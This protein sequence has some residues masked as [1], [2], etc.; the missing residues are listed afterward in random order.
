MVLRKYT[1]L[2]P[3]LVADPDHQQIGSNM[4]HTFAALVAASILVLTAPAQAATSSEAS[5]S[6]PLRALKSAL[7]NDLERALTA[8]STRDLATV[9]A[10]GF[11]LKGVRALAA[12]KASFAARA[13]RVTV[14][15]GSRTFGGRGKSDVRL[16]LTRPGKKMLGRASRITLTVKATFVARTGGRVSASSRMTLERKAVSPPP[17]PIPPIPPNAALL[18]S[19]TFDGRAPWSGLSTQCAHPVGWRS[20]NG[21][22]YAHFEVRPGEPTVAGHERCEVSHGGFGKSL[23]AGEYWYHTRERAGAGFPHETHS[24]HWVDIQQWHEDK[25]PP[26]G[27]TGPV[28]GAMFVNSGSTGRMFIEGDHVSPFLQSAV[29]DIHSWHDF[30]VHGV[31]TDQ[32]HGY[33]EWWIDGVYVGRA[34]GVTSETGGHHFWKGGI[35]RSTSLDTLQSSDITSVQIYRA[36]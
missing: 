10:K 11:T 29:F 20:E 27:S 8:V 6:Q 18:Y 14:A 32:P 35:E 3:V 30:V 23:P 22:G 2:A 21:D 7:R 15:R 12:G 28:D 13:R 24:D 19:Q 25:P 16:K 31:W 5:G 1:R 4:R 26:G 33:L 17:P 9:Q 34:S 36:P